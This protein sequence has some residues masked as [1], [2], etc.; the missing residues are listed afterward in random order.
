[1]GEDWRWPTVCERCSTALDQM[2]FP[3]DQAA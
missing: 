3:P 1:V 2:G